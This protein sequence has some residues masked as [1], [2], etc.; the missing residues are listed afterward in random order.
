VER[1]SHPKVLLLIAHPPAI[2]EQYR[3]RLAAEFPE[4]SVNLVEHHSK[5]DPWIA[6]ADIL[7]TFGAH[8]ADH[9]LEK[10]VKIQWIQALGTGVDGIVDRPAFRPGTLV[11][12]LHGHHGPAVSEAVLAAMLALARDLRRALENQRQH[13]WQRFPATLLAG[14]TV[15][16][17]GI[18]AIAEALAPRCAAM[19]MQVLGVSSTP[20]AVA[21]FA[22]VHGRD[23]LGRVAGEVDFLVLLTPYTAETHE[24]VDR[25]VLAAMKPIVDAGH[26]PVIS[27][28]G[29]LPIV[30][31]LVVDMSPFWEKIRAMKPWLQPGYEEAP[32]GKEYIVSQAKMNPIHKES[33]CIN[34]G[35]DL[36]TG[37]QVEL[38]LTPKERLGIQQSARVLRDAGAVLRQ[39]LLPDRPNMCRWDMRKRW[40]LHGR[41]P[42]GD[43]GRLR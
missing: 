20:R 29:N 33:L 43:G 28:M 10:G 24:L 18:G 42:R 34:C 3:S 37:Q 40:L 15:G 11:T 38:A 13:R 1:E 23:E 9:V 16:I 2:R 27:A 30:K 5:V 41:H 35:L 12:S 21:N 39:H 8:M 32:D 17:V 22:Q 14:K 7:I 6:D 31:D 36:D 25:S 19:D 4:A 26:V